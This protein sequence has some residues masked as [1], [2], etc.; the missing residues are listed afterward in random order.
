MD[1]VRVTAKGHTSLER[2][3][4]TATVL[5][6]VT[7]APQPQLPPRVPTRTHPAYSY[8]AGDPGG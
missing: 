3:G 5:E 2:G 7:G 8:T 6:W 4:G 1:N